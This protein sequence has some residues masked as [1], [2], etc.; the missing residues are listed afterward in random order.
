MALR[1]LR[2]EKACPV[3]LFERSPRFSGGRPDVLGITKTRY[4][5][6][7]EVKRS[8]AD[9]RA[10]SKKNHIIHREHEAF[11]LQAERLALKW[12]KQ[13]WFL[14]PPEL[15]KKVEPWIPD[16]AGLLRGPIDGEP[17]G[18]YC[19]KQSPVNKSSLPGDALSAKETK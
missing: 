7:I 9:F 2:F 3:A 10:N 11:K 5:L 19:V 4:L 12:P 18:V 13:F 17:Q 15:V 1:W 8:F 6:E 16:Y 14:V